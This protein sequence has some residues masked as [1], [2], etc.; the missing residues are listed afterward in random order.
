MLVLM[1]QTAPLKQALGQVSPA[2]ERCLP[3]PPREPQLLLLLLL[4]LIGPALAEMLGPP[5]AGKAFRAGA[6]WLMAGL[7][8]RCPS[9]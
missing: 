3:N 8:H 1:P 4:S 9:E 7:G 6:G 2:A 5:W